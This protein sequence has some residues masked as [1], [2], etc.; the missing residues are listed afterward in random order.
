[1]SDNRTKRSRP[2]LSSVLRTTEK[3]VSTASKSG[4]LVARLGREIVSGEYQPDA[5][6]P[7]EPTMLKRYAVS[8]T[9]LREAYSKLGAKGML[10]A[11]PKVGTSVRASSSWN[12]LDP[13]VLSWHL[14]TL[15][16][17]EIVR[18][19]YNLRRMIEPGA[20][21]MAAEFRSQSELQ[22]IEDAYEN[23]RA[24]SKIEHEL[25]VADLRF[26][27][28][29]LNATHNNFVGAF[30]ALIHAAMMSTFVLS[31]RGAEAIVIKNER[32]LQHGE[33]LEAIREQKPESASSRMLALI[34]DSIGDVSEALSAPA[35]H[36][37]PPQST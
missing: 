11:R 22:E 34:D 19:L 18:D 12:M 35:V 3:P 26:H 6:L 4:G 37:S 1:M 17:E 29:I 36:P 28:A 23:M 27:V 10:V 8:R 31:W 5:R 13:D 32:L 30:S 25:V 33:V 14:E 2:N 24:T 7:D 9:A 21:A 15:Q 16:P 20:A